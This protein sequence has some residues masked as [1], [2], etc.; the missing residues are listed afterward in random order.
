MRR[1]FRLLTIVCFV[2]AGASATALA[3]GPIEKLMMPGELSAPHAK[4]EDNC[5]NC[6]KTFDRQAQNGLCLECHKVIRQDID[7]KQGFH[8]R[9]Q[10]V[11]V[12]D[13]A[14]CHTEHK[15]RDFA[16]APLNPLLFDH[17]ATDFALTGKHKLA[18]CEGCHVKGKKRSEAAHDCFTCHG[19]QQP[20][21]GNLGNKCETCH[22]T[23]TWLKTAAFDHGKTKFPLKGKHAE[24]ACMSCHAGELYVGIGTT[25]NECHALQDV[26]ATRFGTACQDCHTVDKWKDAKFDHGKQTKFPLAGAHAKAQCSDCHGSNT[27]D[28]I[29]MVCADCHKNQDVHKTQL[30]NNCGECHGVVAWA[31]DVK[32]DHGMT[33]YP[34]TGLHVAVACESCHVSRTYKDA[35]QTCIACH[36]ADDTHAGRFASTCENCHSPAGW[37][38]VAFDHGRD[39]HYPLTGAH[40][41]TGCYAC[42]TAKNVKSATLPTDC[43]ACH[44]AQDVHKGAYGKDCARCHSTATFKTAVIKR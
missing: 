17:S 28:K 34:L 12:S 14:S 19:K 10:L 31:K 9:S 36:Q 1:I 15:G 11:G 18:D 32:F 20:H 27:R 2:L 4:L 30:G 24:V 42:H 8:G 7:K 38:R 25:C 40:A 5:Q 22:S 39:T 44:K 21:K 16:I 37:Q 13:C 3:A 6:H 23:D 33:R 35:K 43:F 41:T 29:S 26:H